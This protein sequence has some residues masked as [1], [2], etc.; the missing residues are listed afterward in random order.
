MNDTQGLSRRTVRIKVLQHKKTDLLLAMSDDLSG[1]MV[2]ARSE[3][4]LMGKIPAA[5][6]E[7]LEAQG[8]DVVSV[9]A[10]RDDPDFPKDFAPPAYLADALVRTA[11]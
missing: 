9:E 2:P 8:A 6:Q 7:I 5:V 3:K 10:V 1:L 11:Y 4:E